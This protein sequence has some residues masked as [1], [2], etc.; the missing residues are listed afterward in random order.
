MVKWRNLRVEMDN[1]IVMKKE[2]IKSLYIFIPL[3]LVMTYIYYDRARGIAMSILL[4]YI[5]ALCV[6]FVPY[7]FKRVKK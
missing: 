3:G 7:L 4:G 6:F 5:S 2:F 1:L